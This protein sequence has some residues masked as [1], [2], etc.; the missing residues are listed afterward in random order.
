VTQSRKTPNFADFRVLYSMDILVIWIFDI[1]L[2]KK[3]TWTIVK[4]LGR[5][6]VISHG[7]NIPFLRSNIPWIR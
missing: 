1:I 6:P 2:T 4:T 5:E 7:Q 3:F